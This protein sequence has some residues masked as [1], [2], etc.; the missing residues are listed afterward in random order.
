MI[1]LRYV[2]KKK[3]NENPHE[4]QGTCRH[5]PRGAFLL[6]GGRFWPGVEFEHDPGLRY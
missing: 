3:K 6:K 4:T 5:H 1:Q 2:S